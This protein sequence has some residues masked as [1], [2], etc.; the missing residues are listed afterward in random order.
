MRALII[1]C[2]TGEGHNSCAKAIKE[3]FDLN[4]EYCV[5]ADGLQFI[6][7]KASSFISGGHVFLY[8]HFPLIF[9]LGYKYSENHSGTFKADSFFII[10][11]Q[12]VQISFISIFPTEILIPLFALIR[13]LLLC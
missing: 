8:R 6:S 13:L 3:V 12:K 10:I 4:G 2:N 7:K 1:S 5:I 9:N 11:L